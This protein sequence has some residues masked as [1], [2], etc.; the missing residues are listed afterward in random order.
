MIFVYI[1][2]ATFVHFFGENHCTH[3]D[4]SGM[5]QYYI[6]FFAIQIIAILHFIVYHLFNLMKNINL[7]VEF[8][9]IDF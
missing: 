5:R 8:R 6:A 4:K 3:R 2:E 7:L 9:R 1:I